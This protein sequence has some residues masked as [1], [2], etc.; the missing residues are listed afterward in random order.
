MAVPY[1]ASPMPMIK[2]RSKDGGMSRL[3]SLPSAAA[4]PGQLPR[5]VPEGTVP[6]VAVEGTAYDCGRWYGEIVRERYPGYDHYLKDVGAFARPPG[7]AQRLLERHAPHVTEIYRGLAASAPGGG[8][9][10]PSAIAHHTAPVEDAGGCTSFGVSGEVTLDGQPVSGQTKD[11][12]TSAVPLYIAL[13]MRIK[14]APT[15]LVLAYPGEV[16]GHGMWSTGMTIFRN[17][18]YSS[19]AAEGGLSMREWALLALAGASVEDGAHMARRHGVHGEGACLI[20][21][22]DG[23]SLTVEFNAGGVGIVPAKDGVATHAN[24]PEAPETLPFDCDWSRHGHGP[25]EREQSDW[26]AQGLRAMIDA[27]RGRFT[28]QRALMFLADHTYYPQSICRHWID[29][30]PSSETVSAVVAEP[31]KGLLH[32]VRGQPCA[33]WPVTYTV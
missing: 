3:Y 21:D 13:R 30:K 1:D 12:G 17:S 5:R 28:A 33:N 29:G 31:G 24:H 7:A 27:E 18:L 23:R 26:R 8:D 6:L 14:D 20:S 32:V 11:V 2:S 22:G 10:E 25:S 16:L 4:P 9:A 19:A 15:I